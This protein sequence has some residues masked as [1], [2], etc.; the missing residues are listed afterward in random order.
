MQIREKK[1]PH[2]FVTNGGGVT[3]ETKAK[4]LSK[5]FGL[6]V[7]PSQILLSHTPLKSL[8]PE[9]GDKKVFIL[10]SKNYIEVAKNYGFRNV[11]TAHDFHEMCPEC[12]PARPANGGKMQD[13]HPHHSHGIAAAIIVYDPVDWALEM[14]VLFDV[15]VDHTHG[16]TMHQVVPL[17]ACNADVVY[18][19]QHHHPR[20][21]Q[22]AFVEAF[23]GLFESYT[24]SPLTVRFFGKPFLVQY[25]MAEQMLQSQALEMGIT[26]PLQRFAGI[27]DNPKADVRGANGAGDHWTSVLVHTGVYKPSQV[28]PPIDDITPLSDNDAHD[29]ADIVAS[30]VL[31]AIRILFHRHSLTQ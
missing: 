21:T 19:D 23:R 1:V 22:G 14:Q 24:K 26:T 10:G 4:E 25:Q 7:S 20:F 28:S 8:V 13:M 17:Y 3:E 2:V 30:D 18:M 5:K 6:T 15:L 12:F 16:S 27:G 9:F 31:H 29:P 11:I